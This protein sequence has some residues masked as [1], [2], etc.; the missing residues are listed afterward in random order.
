MVGLKREAN[1]YDVVSNVKI[2][3]AS[4]DY[5][6]MDYRNRIAIQE[7]VTIQDEV[8]CLKWHTRATL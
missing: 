1:F 4:V 6:F 7:L 3:E 5:I 8:K 2:Q